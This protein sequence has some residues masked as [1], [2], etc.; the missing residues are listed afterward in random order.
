MSAANRNSA[1]SPSQYSGAETNASAVPIAA[2]SSHV[3]RRT[4][5]TIPTESPLTSQITTAPAASETVAG[6]RSAIRLRT[7]ALE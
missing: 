1:I 2:R 4:A 6:R 5:E 7:E 3:R